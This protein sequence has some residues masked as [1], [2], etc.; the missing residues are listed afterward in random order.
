MLFSHYYWGMW[1][2]IMSKNDKI[3]FDYISFAYSRFS[4]YLLIKN[5]IKL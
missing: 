5:K 4:K 2:I 3:S 1:A